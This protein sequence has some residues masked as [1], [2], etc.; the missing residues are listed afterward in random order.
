MCLRRSTL[1]RLVLDSP[2]SK[3][4]DA[5]QLGRA[6]ASPMKPVPKD[7]VDFRCDIRDSE[8]KGE[9][10]IVV[11]TRTENVRTGRYGGDSIDDGVQWPEGCAAQQKS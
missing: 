10:E 8:V 7:A 4:C 5:W 6:S 3:D 1:H 2:K 9:G 11:E